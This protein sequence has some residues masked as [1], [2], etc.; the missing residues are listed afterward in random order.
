MA[1]EFINIDFFKDEE[2]I[3]E[4]IEDYQKLITE[5]L[6][7]K[8]P[9]EDLKNYLES[10]IITDI[11]S[12][13]GINKKDL[14]T[15]IDSYGISTNGVESIGNGGIDNAVE[16]ILPS[17]V[18]KIPIETKLSNFWGG[19]NTSKN[20]FIKDFKI[21]VTHY[22]QTHTGKPDFY[23]FYKSELKD[24]GESLK[25][26]QINQGTKLI[27]YAE[28]PEKYKAKILQTLQELQPI[29][30][31]YDIKK[32]F[33]ANDSG[34][35]S[36]I[37][38][39]R[40]CAQYFLADPMNF[41]QLLQHVL[42]KNLSINNN[43]GHIS[44]RSDKYQINYQQTAIATW[45]DED[46]YN[47]SKGLSALVENTILGWNMYRQINGSWTVQ[48]YE[49]PSD[50]ITVYN[51]FSKILTLGNSNSWASIK[52]NLDEITLPFKKLNLIANDDFIKNELLNIQTI[53]DLISKV[54]EHPFRLLPIL[55]KAIVSTSFFDK[56]H[57]DSN[58]T[59]KIF[60]NDNEIALMYTIWENM[61][62]P[63]NSDSLIRKAVNNDQQNIIYNQL[64]ASFLSHEQKQMY[65]IEETY[66]GIDK[67]YYTLKRANK[68]LNLLQE[69]I[70]GQYSPNVKKTYNTIE[71][72]PEQPNDKEIL[73][74]LQIKIKDVGSFI[75]AGTEVKTVNLD[76]NSLRTDQDYRTALRNMI[77]FFSEVIGLDFSANYKLPLIE[78]CISTF[79][80]AENAFKSLLKIAGSLVYAHYVSQLHPNIQ[81]K[82]DFKNE[83]SKHYSRKVELVGNVSYGQINVFSAVFS[84][85][86]RLSLAY[87]MNQGITTDII[88]KGGSG[89]SISAIILSTLATKWGQW[90]QEM[91]N[92][93]SIVQEFSTKNLYEV[94]SFFRDYTDKT[95]ENKSAVKMS[96]EELFLSNFLYDFYNP[97][98][99]GVVLGVLSDKPNLAR[100]EGRQ[101][102]LN[103]LLKTTDKVSAVK[104]LVKKELGNFYMNLFIEMQHNLDIL[105]K[106]SPV[107]LNL[108]TDY[109]EI[110][111]LGYSRSQIEQI[112]HDAILKAQQNG[113][114]VSI[115]DLLYF[116]WDKNTL[117]VK[118]T[119]VAEIY[120][121]SDVV[122]NQA[123][124][125]KI[126]KIKKDQKHSWNSLQNLESI[127]EFFDRKEQEFILNLI[128]DLP[129]GIRYTDIT[130]KN[131][132]SP[133]IATLLRENRNWTTN[134]NVILAKFISEEETP[135]V[136]NITTK[137]SIKNWWIYRAIETYYKDQ[138][139][140]LE[141]I[142][143]EG[144][145]NFKNFITLLEG[146]SITTSTGETFDL[147]TIL[148]YTNRKQIAN[149]E[150]NVI[151]K[152]YAKQY[153]ENNTQQM[154]IILGSLNKYLME[155]QP[156]LTEEE[157]KV[158]ALEM[159][160]RSKQRKTLPSVYGHAMLETLKPKQRTKIL[161][162]I[163]QSND[164]V[165]KNFKKRKEELLSN[166]EKS[167][168]KFEF[169]INPE[170]QRYNALG[171]LIG[172]EGQINLVGTHVNHDVPYVSDVRLMTSLEAG[173]VA[174]RNVAIS[175]A[176]S[177]YLR[178]SLKGVAKTALVAVIPDTRGHISTIN[179]VENPKGSKPMD[180]GT[181]ANYSFRRQ[182]QA[183]L[184]PQASG[185]D[186]AKPVGN[187]Y[188][189][190]TGTAE[191]LKTATFV[192]TNWRIRHSDR[193][194]RLHR[195]MT[196][197]PWKLPNNKATIGITQGSYVY[198]R[199]GWVVD[200]TKDYNGQNIEYKPVIV[201]NPVN[202]KY[203]L[204]T[205]FKVDYSTGLTSFTEYDIND[206]TQYIQSY[207][208]KQPLT[209][210]L[211]N[212]RKIVTKRTVNS[213]YDLWNV[214]GGAYS[215]HINA[216][217]FSFEYEND[218]T[219]LEN[220]YIASYQVGDLHYNESSK[221]ISQTVPTV[222]D[223]ADVTLPIRDGKIDLIVTAG[224]M[225]QGAA[226][227]NYSPKTDA[228]GKSLPLSY[229]AALDDDTYQ[230]TTFR[231]S[232]A[233][234]GIQLNPEHHTDDSKLT[235]MTQVV[236]ALGLRG[237]SNQEAFKCYKALSCL[238]NL[239]LSELFDGISKTINEGNNEDFKQAVSD[240]LL[241]AIINSSTNKGDLISAI[242]YN[243]QQELINNPTKKSYDIIRDKLPISDPAI[244][245][246]FI[247]N[248]NALM[249]KSGIRIP[250]AGSMNVL[251]PSDGFYK[252]H[253]GV[254]RQKLNTSKYVNSD[255][256]F[257][258]DFS[259][260]NEEKELKALQEE[261]DKHPLELYQLIIGGAYKF[262]DA[263][264]NTTYITLESKQDYLYLRNLVR[265]SKKS[266]K[267]YKV[268]EDV[269]KGRDLAPYNCTFEDTDGHTYM[270]WDL[271]SVQ[272]L[273]EVE[274]WTP[275][276]LSE[277]YHDYINNQKLFNEHTSLILDT[278]D[279]INFR[280]SLITVLRRNLQRDLNGIG[281]GTT[282]R[283][284]VLTHVDSESMSTYSNIIVNK[285]TLKVKPYELIASKNY[286][287]SFG[288]K[289]GDNLTDIKDDPN[290][291]L[292]RALNLRQ[293]E[294]LKID[295]KNYDI[296]LNTAS[297]N[298]YY[299][300]QQTET[301]TTE[302]LHKIQLDIDW[303][304][305][306][307]YAL[308]SDGKPKYKVPWHKDENGNIVYD[309]TLY[310]DNKGNEIIYT[311][312]VTEFLNDLHF[313]YITFGKHQNDKKQ[314][315][316]SLQDCNKHSVQDLIKDIFTEVL[317]K[318]I[319]KN[320]I[321][322]VN[323]SDLQTI[324]DSI[325]EQTENELNLLQN[326]LQAAKGKNQVILS[327]NY[328]SK[329]LRQMIKAS[330]ELHTSFIE[331]LNFIVSRTPA[332]SHQSFMPMVLVGFDESGLNSAYV[333]R[334]QLYLQ[335][336][337]FDVDK[338]S[339]LGY[340]FL[341]GK[342][343]TWSLYMR[344]DDYELF[345]ASENLPFPTG[346]KL[347]PVEIS[348]TKNFPRIY[349]YLEKDI[350]LKWHPDK[351]VTFE[352]G[353]HLFHFTRTVQDDKVSFILNEAES[354]ILTSSEF[355]AYN[356]YLL[357]NALYDKV[358]DNAIVQF[359][360]TN[361]TFEI[362]GFESINSS[363]FKK[364]ASKYSNLENYREF[365]YTI[366]IFNS[367]GS[368]N[369][370]TPESLKQLAILIE[371]LSSLGVYP[372]YQPINKVST[373][374]SQDKIYLKGSDFQLRL[375]KIVNAVDK[376]NTYLNKSSLA[377]DATINYISY[378]TYKISSDP[379]NGQQAQTSVDLLTYVIKDITK[380]RPLAKQ[381]EH[382]DPGNEMSKF[383]LARLTLSGKDNTGIEASALKVY[384]AEYQYTCYVLNH[385]T[386]EQQKRL[387]VNDLNI[388]GKDCTLLANTFCRNI[389]NVKDYE[390]YVALQNVDNDEDIV[391]WLSAFLSLSTDNAKDPTLSKINAGPE[392]IGLYNAGFALGFDIYT[393]IDLIDSNTGR[394]L[395]EMQQGNILI[396][397]PGCST[398]G[399]AINQLYK[400]PN[401]SYLTN[402]CLDII[403]KCYKNFYGGGEVT[404]DSYGLANAILGGR[405]LSNIYRAKQFLQYL[406]SAVYSDDSTEVQNLP[407]LES[408]IKDNL[409]RKRRRLWILE[410]K[411][412]PRLNNQ[413]NS[414]K[415]EKNITKYN[416]EL[417]ECRQ[418]ITQLEDIYSSLVLT[419]ELPESNEG[420]YK[421]AKQLKENL[422]KAANQHYTMYNKKLDYR[423]VQSDLETFKRFLLEFEAH[424]NRLERIALDSPTTGTDGNSY[425]K[426][427]VLSQI[428][429]KASEMSLIRP[430]LA[431]NQQLP[432][433]QEDMIAFI[434]K[435]EEIISTRLREG[436]I[437]ELPEAVKN[438][439]KI[440][441][442]ELNI[443]INKFLYD[444][445]YQKAAID[446]Y[447]SIKFQINV[448]EAIT[449]LPHYFGYLQTAG[450]SYKAMMERSIQF[451][452]QMRI[453]RE[454]LRKDLK[455]YGNTEIVQRLKKSSEYI[456]RT[457]NT[458]F[459]QNQKYTLT[460]NGSEYQLGFSDA[461]KFFKKWME[462]VVIP[463]LKTQYPQNEFIKALTIVSYNKNASHNT[464][465]NY[466]T[467]VQQITN[468]QPQIQQF[469][470]V[471]EGLLD[472]MG[473]T[474][475]GKP[476][477]DLFFL[478]DLIAY[479]RIPSQTAL[480]P[481]FTNLMRVTDNT[482]ISAYTT[483]ISQLDTSGEYIIDLKGQKMELEQYIAPTISM[484]EL[485][486]TKEKYVF[487][488]DVS[489]QYKLVSI[490][491]QYEKKKGG[492]FDDDDEPNVE[493]DPAYS[494]EDEDHGEEGEE[495]GPRRI[496]SLSS[497][498][499]SL[500]NIKRG[501]ATIVFKILYDTTMDD[502]DSNISTLS[503]DSRVKTNALVKDITTNTIT[504]TLG[505]ED[506]V[507]D[508]ADT[509]K[510]SRTLLNKF[511]NLA[512]ENGNP[513]PTS[514][515]DVIIVTTSQKEKKIDIVKT[516][517]NLDNLITKN[518]C[519]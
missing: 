273:T 216:T 2:N 42:Q 150:D 136:K 411:V 517:N 118:P 225:K 452:E 362:N 352:V 473:A 462:E 477:I 351:S 398:V 224:A 383:R 434:T 259:E 55:F 294:I 307:A 121:Y 339:M 292:E 91:G 342:F 417:A 371:G 324:I 487:I 99:F 251:V 261:A 4:T 97:D 311:S 83:V 438:F 472:L 429:Q 335:G 30:Q 513:E 76:N 254:L 89:E 459:L 62:D 436:E 235:L 165:Y 33:Y 98:R 504:F 518:E 197:I 380:T 493:D 246:K 158:K 29:I 454:I 386:T 262:I 280:Q 238:T 192:L 448:L 326:E 425:N 70:L 444:K 304:G 64:I 297:G 309:A 255:E 501:K 464:T 424:L 172:E 399:Q 174:K 404:L 7:Q 149:L 350:D 60:F 453:L 401:F 130:G 63:D 166:Q 414:K 408:I 59:Q 120:K 50:V 128:Q 376:H 322:V 426:L 253:G 202:K 44:S 372:V 221:G 455:V 270:L 184:G 107:K 369:T 475:Q 319:P 258:N 447:D 282:R 108:W 370:E 329:E 442:N 397:R 82:N 287:T 78:T 320:A 291:F 179:G 57:Y 156:K 101:E 27:K 141:D 21:K 126:Q 154:N 94:I 23:E 81:N 389:A 263:E 269:I 489:G 114:D 257:E 492:E 443:D 244:M 494:Y 413:Q 377:K 135:K 19:Y 394:V 366:N 415:R 161:K 175:A 190:K 252:L 508:L 499:E 200:F 422:D 482:L 290:F 388:L 471:S 393:L 232:T 356:R 247:S 275:K 234:L 25:E 395:S 439:K 6:S 368:V 476:I 277:A 514:I 483:Y 331:S 407:S 75:I 511:K 509:R 248:F 45:Q 496:Q 281:S 35:I 359:K 321:E 298:N 274:N 419:G 13:Q 418:S 183:S 160:N 403:S 334:Y 338:A 402:S 131:L 22:I 147:K 201:Y 177:Q 134:S 212:S 236:N 337:D 313:S 450:A 416:T 181:F 187:G 316:E 461:N 458:K 245:H 346:T 133:S 365:I 391:T 491:K 164:E 138:N 116:S 148:T 139:L 52:I 400:G 219:S 24:L 240:L 478:Y 480:T 330:Q 379:V 318:E 74:S 71:I 430:I 16:D 103:S 168:P 512:K 129:N 348:D 445:D 102:A 31:N 421:I 47:V 266:G 345:K 227:V 361:I 203:T 314:L 10:D 485:A 137:D 15:F 125:Q 264:G 278:S 223:D 132:K 363:Q 169:K 157:R 357:L 340:R 347:K 77:S 207:L 110:N 502:L 360:N 470:R 315:I 92:A 214:F 479:N 289:V 162:E 34:Q 191:F 349:D 265:Q 249:T 12:M 87:D 474:Y 105:N 210:L 488:K 409:E 325:S 51:V 104:N 41:D 43:F 343:I 440:N 286:A 9:K 469:E 435:F 256:L 267:E 67:N 510:S 367:D 490:S 279:I 231:M 390:V 327:E 1:C 300:I 53:S 171:Y 100:F 79:G 516:L 222:I 381:T 385:G 460:I 515:K 306:I 498:I 378:Q 93:D 396:K 122:Q 152:Y 317:G 36:D 373:V 354:K 65:G 20:Q 341:N 239:Q 38:I 410:N 308:G 204:R 310:V 241:R 205:D 85:I 344:L 84:E 80:S 151:V 500:Q 145:F 189:P 106:Y 186:N 39:A 433:S 167:I 153:D 312:K 46:N 220:V 58:N 115:N 146:N 283:I 26:S 305:E 243:L 387:L 194:I 375:A 505:G 519:K 14:I 456:T 412:L 32:Q 163:D 353:G 466:S 193:N 428:N 17:T 497:Y 68:R 364:D 208:K 18:R 112:I 296:C 40:I 3:P 333:S 123:Y 218:N 111:K 5:Y 272:Q 465:N 117:H 159:Y 209:H 226:N 96:T 250:V 61:F 215:V 431:L 72:I 503:S 486:K 358:D 406:K 88:V 299:I 195:K 155:Q 495:E 457:I 144:E 468:S 427:K 49:H 228:K 229:N 392:M 288:L 276:Q 260:D 127:E 143:L 295:P 467:Q 328:Q 109:A 54:N 507:Y 56:C 230:L 119:L 449:M 332:Q 384:E 173:Q 185:L 176:K 178:T 432:N 382:F 423:E 198:T 86:F 233:D 451:R 48:I 355:S 302:G 446:A 206:P 420:E 374:L 211:T 11:L 217:T 293:T 140:P 506:I 199:N 268:V 188:N 8:T 142:N 271:E 73:K 95:G 301:S 69:K 180:G 28:N 303:D 90:L 336:S 284:R 484:Y 124:R 242:A 437:K 405:D 323:G 213:N 463:D 285:E 182:E 481:L 441:D 170:L 113:E 237:F 66:E 37:I 196:H